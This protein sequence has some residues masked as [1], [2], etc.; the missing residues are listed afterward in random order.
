MA[1]PERPERFRDSGGCILQ[2]PD[3]GEKKTG[4]TDPQSTCFEVGKVVAVDLQ[5]I[6]DAVEFLHGIDVGAACVS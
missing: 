4:G 6:F 1:L 5:I 2:R 3:A